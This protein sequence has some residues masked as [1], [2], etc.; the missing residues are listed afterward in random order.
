MADKNIHNEIQGLPLPK[1]MLRA[2]C[3]KMTAFWP[4]IHISVF[5][6]SENW[7]SGDRGESMNDFK[8]WVGDRILNDR[9]LEDYRD[10][11]VPCLKEQKPYFQRADGDKHT[12]L[13]AA[14]PVGVYSGDSGG[15][16]A[17]DNIVGKQ[18]IWSQKILLC[19]WRNEQTVLLLD[20]SHQQ[21]IE[22]IVDQLSLYSKLYGV[23]MRYG[24][25]IRSLR[26]DLRTPL[27]SITMISG[28]LQQGENNGELPEIGQMLFAAAEKMDGLLRSLES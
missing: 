18:T 28:L 14:M 1:D 8:I 9:V 27:T 13:L 17:A 20:R 21:I 23:I 19:F 4:F 15:L 26:H 10:V 12:D 16:G 7:L 6:V 3:K 24:L 11:F 5:S 25:L 2:V 22:L